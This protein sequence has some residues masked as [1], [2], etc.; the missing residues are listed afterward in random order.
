[1]RT[2]F[3]PALACLLLVGSIAPA[4]APT[5]PQDAGRHAPRMAGKLGWNRRTLAGAYDRVGK[6]DARWD[7]PAREA[8]ELAALFFSHSLEPQVTLGDLHR[9]TQTALAAGCDD[10]LIQYLDA[11]S[12]EKAGPTAADEQER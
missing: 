4:A 9:A 5:I 1:M 6:K 10:P 8:L 12:F 11:R 7:A 3:V 2:R